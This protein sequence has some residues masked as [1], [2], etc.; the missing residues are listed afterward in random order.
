[1]SSA[2]LLSAAISLLATVEWRFLPDSD[3]QDGQMRR[4]GAGS[5]VLSALPST[6]AVRAALRC[7]ASCE[8]ASRIPKP[9]L[10]NEPAPTALQ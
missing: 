6:L 4:V 1:M 8:Q 10:A 5:L 7:A 3:I 9:S 2:M